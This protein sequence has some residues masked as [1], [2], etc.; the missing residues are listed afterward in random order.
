MRWQLTERGRMQM[1]KL[2]AN[3]SCIATSFSSIRI[4]ASSMR[5]AASGPL[6]SSGSSRWHAISDADENSDMTTAENAL[7]GRP[8]SIGMKDS[9]FSLARAKSFLAS[10]GVTEVLAAG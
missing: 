6:K 8:G 3:T 7:P 4:V 5:K 2:T 10:S 9:F 1:E